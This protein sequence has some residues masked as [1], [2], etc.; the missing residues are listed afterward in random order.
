MKNVLLLFI[1]SLLFLGCKDSYVKEP[2]KLIEKDKMVDIIYD[3]SLLEAM[4]TQ[5][6]GVPTNY[7][8]STV[9]LKTKYKVDSLTFAENTKF[10]ASDVEEY[11]KIYEKVKDRLKKKLDSEN[12]IGRIKAPNSADEGIVK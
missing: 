1:L 5:N 7:P 8:T 11:K 4:K 2:K 12:G 3:L 9:F 6:I 10:Y